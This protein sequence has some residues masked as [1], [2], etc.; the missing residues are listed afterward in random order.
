VAVADPL[1]LDRD[2]DVLL[3]PAIRSRVECVVGD[4]TY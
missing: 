1:E 4:G 2:V 3:V